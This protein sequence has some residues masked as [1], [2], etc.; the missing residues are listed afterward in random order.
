MAEQI[1]LGLAPRADRGRFEPAH[2]AISCRRAVARVQVPGQRGSRDAAG[3]VVEADQRIE[4]VRL[5]RHGHRASHLSVIGSQ[6][7]AEDPK[8]LTDAGIEITGHAA[9]HSGGI[10][11]PGCSGMAD[12]EGPDLF[13][14][15]IGSGHDAFVPDE[16]QQAPIGRVHGITP[17]ARGSE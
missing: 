11:R 12:A 7:G 9:W 16:G 13:H 8:G 14:I 1:A 3:V 5:E 15:E 2:E 10:G 17:E 6:I 4:F